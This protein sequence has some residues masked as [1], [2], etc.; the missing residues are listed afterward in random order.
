MVGS[1]LICLIVLMLTIAIAKPIAK[2]GKETKV[3]GKKPM[4]KEEDVFVEVDL[5]DDEDYDM[6]EK[7]EAEM[8][9]WEEV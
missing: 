8:A 3:E 2:P 6:V 1:L 5:N 9:E 4:G 7:E